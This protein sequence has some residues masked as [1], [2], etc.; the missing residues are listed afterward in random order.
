MQKNMMWIKVTEMDKYTNASLPVFFH[1][2]RAFETYL[3]KAL[4]IRYLP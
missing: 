4:Q 3:S 2:Q 1:R